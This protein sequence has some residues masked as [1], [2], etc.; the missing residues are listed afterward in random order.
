MAKQSGFLQRLQ[1]E[2]QIIVQQARRQARTYMLDMVTVALGRM[3]MREKRLT[4]FDK[5]LDE[6]CQEYGKVILEDS[7]SDPDIWYGKECLD[8]E[9]RKYV[10]SRFVPFDERYS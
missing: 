7:E 4:E 8:R 2:R 10:G 9:L 1:L 5:I 3:G 6:V